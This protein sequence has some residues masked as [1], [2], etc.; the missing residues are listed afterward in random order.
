MELEKNNQNSIMTSIMTTIKWFF[1]ISGIYLLWITLHYASG[2]LY[3]KYCTPYSVFG[4]LASPVLAASP[5][6]RGLRWVIST[7]GDI[8]VNMWVIIGTWIAAKLCGNLLNK[9]QNQNQN[10]NQNKIKNDT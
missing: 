8:I 6:C 3:S 4:F 7:G 2:I 9:N 10:Q 5:H 1:E